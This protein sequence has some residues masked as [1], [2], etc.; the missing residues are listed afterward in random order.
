MSTRSVEFAPS[1]RGGGGIIGPSGLG[2][3]GPQ[4]SIRFFA[5]VRR[6]SSSKAAYRLTGLEA[7]KA[8]R[9]RAG[10][11]EGSVEVISAIWAA[12]GA[13]T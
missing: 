4:L 8:R 11:I 10:V 9:I 1:G 7:G 6:S 3:Q 12:D 5:L 2:G 13:M